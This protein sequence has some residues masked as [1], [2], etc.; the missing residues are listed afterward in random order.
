V[1]GFGSGFGWAGEVEKNKS[2][3]SMGIN[4][5]FMSPSACWRMEKQGGKR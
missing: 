5:R 1:L 4:T 3:A 2:A